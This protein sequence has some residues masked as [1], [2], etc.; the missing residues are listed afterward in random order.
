MPSYDDIDSIVADI[1]K[2]QFAHEAVCAERYKNLQSD[3]SAL[4]LE[5]ARHRDALQ[6]LS[7]NTADLPEM[8]QALARLV[9]NMNKRAGISLTVREIVMA[10]F[11][12]ASIAA[13][14]YEGV[15]VHAG[16]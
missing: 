13:A 2:R 3:V 7:T 11:S 5:G 12:V 4:K 1:D 9:E 8:K 15:L 6:A 16:K 10:V 14:L